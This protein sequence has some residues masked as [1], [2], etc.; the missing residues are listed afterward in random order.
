MLVERKNEPAPRISAAEG[1]KLVHPRVVGLKGV[2]Y[3]CRLI[4]AEDA[5]T[6]GKKIQRGTRARPSVFPRSWLTLI[7]RHIFIFI[8]CVS[9]RCVAAGVCSSKRR[10]G[11][12]RI[13]RRGGAWRCR[14]RD[15]APACSRRA[16]G[17]RGAGGA[18]RAPAHACLFTNLRPAG[19]HDRRP[20]RRRR[21]HRSEGDA[22]RHRGMDG[23]QDRAH[24][25]LI[26]CLPDRIFHWLKASPL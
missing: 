7:M 11:G 20:H 18:H 3:R 13:E 23:D 25:G 12:D 2:Q 14:K 9:N 16:V 17:R 26:A 15:L 8:I 10:S 22:R 1:K 5:A 19:V 24:F 21:P 4:V 6:G